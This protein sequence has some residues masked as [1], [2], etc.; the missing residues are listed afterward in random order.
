MK[1]DYALINGRGYP[2]TANPDNL[3][4]HPDSGGRVSQM[5]S[6]LIT[7]TKGETILLRLNNLSVT[8][9]FTVTV[10]GIPMKVVGKDTRELVST[11]GDKLH[12]FTSS[13]NIGGG[14]AFDVILYTDNIPV[15][16]YYL[17]TTNL[18]YLSNGAEDFGGIMTE[19]QI[20]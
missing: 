13:V 14:E 9:Y 1:D 7:V 3:D 8:E 4:P 12:Y 2:D 20:K 10:L 19:I 11:S 16:T 17:Y 6:S 5:I 15:G 18:N